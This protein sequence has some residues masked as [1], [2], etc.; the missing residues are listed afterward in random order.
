MDRFRELSTFVAV[1]E[2]GAFNA[3]ARRLNTSPPVVT[4]LVTALETRIGARLLTRTTRKLA[5]TEAGARLL[6]DAARLLEELAEIEASA[7]GA[8]RSPQGTLRVTAPVMF[9][10]RY[11]LPI[12]RDFLDAHPRVSATTL[13]VDRIV[14]LIDEGLDVALRIGALPDSTLSATRIGVV[15]RVTVASPAY[16]A[17]NGTPGTPDALA[18]HRIIIQPLTLYEAPRW[19]FVAAGE[20]RVVPVAPRFA[21]NTVA[22][23]LNS[24]IAGWGITRA[25]SYQVADALTEGTLVEIL[26]DWEDRELP[27]PLVH[28]EGR[29]SAAKTRAFIDFAATRLRAD[30]DRLAAL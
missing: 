30:A 6:A 21:A 25:L 20:T 29:L 11:V 17:A 27:I 18:A 8:H 22:A 7:A 23:V 28:A 10:H 3:A 13:F 2:E 9:G 4:R 12:L 15:R 1:A 19:P 5:L 14:D 24:A 26:R 16:L